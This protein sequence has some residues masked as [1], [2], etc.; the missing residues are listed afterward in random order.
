MT[1]PLHRIGQEFQA[2]CAQDQFVA[3]VSAEDRFNWRVTF[4]GPPRSVYEEGTFAINIEIPHDFPIAGTSGYQPQYGPWVHLLTPIYHCNVQP[5]E[6]ADRIAFI[7]S[8]PS[9]EWPHLRWEPGDTILYMARR[10]YAMLEHPLPWSCGNEEAAQLFE[11]DRPRYDQRAR[12][13]VERH[14]SGPMPDAHSWGGARTPLPVPLVLTLSAEPECVGR[15]RVRCTNELGASRA[16][17][18]IQ[19]RWR[20]EALRNGIRAQVLDPCLKLYHSDGRLLS[21]AYDEEPLVR[22]F[23]LDGERIRALSFREEVQNQARGDCIRRR[24]VVM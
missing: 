24:C 17:V 18:D 19:K 4:R 7:W 3:E 12:E 6:E 23:R 10:T 14:A 5:Q 9:L 22:V 13:W 11:R 21:E 8:Y 16:E 1:T 20:L 2:F 15:L